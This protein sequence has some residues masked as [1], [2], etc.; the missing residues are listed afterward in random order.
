LK[1][2]LPISQVKKDYSAMVTAAVNPA[3]NSDCVT[4]VLGVEFAT[5][6]GAHEY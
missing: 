1:E 2:S 4:D 5:V 3:A 6:V